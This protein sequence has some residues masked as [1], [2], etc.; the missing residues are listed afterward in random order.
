MTDQTRPARTPEYEDN[1]PPPVPCPCCGNPMEA[2]YQPPLVENNPR[3]VGF[4]LVTCQHDDC[5]H[6]STLS[7]RHFIQW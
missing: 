5:D 1:P 6:N 7:A 4:W 3:F 2:A